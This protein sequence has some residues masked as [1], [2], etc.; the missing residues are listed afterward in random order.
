MR[1]LFSLCFLSA[2]VVGSDI[3]NGWDF[4]YSEEH[5]E[6]AAAV[7]VRLAAKADRWV[8]LGAV[9]HLCR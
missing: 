4:D 1:H 8:G 5:P 6:E 7:Q 2:A 9:L 3:D